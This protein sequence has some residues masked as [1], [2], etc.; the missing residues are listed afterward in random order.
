MV[1]VLQLVTTDIPSV[2]VTVVG[3]HTEVGINSVVVVSGSVEVSVI[4]LVSTSRERLVEEPI[5]SKCIREESKGRKG[6]HYA[7]QTMFGW[8]QKHN[9]PLRPRQ[10]RGF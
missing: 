5:T 2:S 7:Y 1:R 3:A 10:G 4:V 8:A 9:Q 6:A